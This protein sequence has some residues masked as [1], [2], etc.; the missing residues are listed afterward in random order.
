MLQHMFLK[1]DSANDVSEVFSRK[2]WSFVLS[3]I[4]YQI[5][6]NRLSKHKDVQYQYKYFIL[7][8]L[9]MKSIFYFDLSW[10]AVLASNIAQ[11]YVRYYKIILNL[12]VYRRNSL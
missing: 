7:F 6:Y 5:T 11:I 8:L 9:R 1:Y 4:K 3:Y 10:D 12:Q 2:V